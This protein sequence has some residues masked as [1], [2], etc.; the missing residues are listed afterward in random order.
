MRAARILCAFGGLGLLAACSGD[1]LDGVARMNEIEVS[2]SAAP[3]QL[4]ASPTPQEVGGVGFLGRL[5]GRA[6]SDS[7]DTAAVDAAVAE[8][9]PGSTDDT[10]ETGTDGGEAVA[11][12]APEPAPEP[13]RRGFLGGLFRGNGG[14]SDVT[15]AALG[16]SSTPRSGPDARIVEPGTTLAF[17]EIATVCGIRG[18]ALG[19]KIEE[20]AGY[21][22]YDTIPNATAPR[23]MYITGFD[24]GCARTVTATVAVWGDVGT[25]EVVRYQRH[26]DR[27]PYSATDR[28]YEEIKARVCRVGT[29]KPCGAR[30]EQLGRDM[31]FLTL[32]N[33]FGGATSWVDVLFYDGEVVAIGRSSGG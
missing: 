1:P 27:I 22:L 3:A 14:R 19:R 18:R 8:A 5:F 29:G 2:S 32:Y 28:A 26:N 4:A 15:P 21:T 10:A 6:D 17:G 12:A 11:V 9:L 16:T 30:L 23:P 20:V 31:M 33:T 24:D 13:Q 25:H 7:A